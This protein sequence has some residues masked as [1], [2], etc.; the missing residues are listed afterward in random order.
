[1]PLCLRI[2]IGTTGTSSTL[3]YRCCARSAP[4]SAGKLVGLASWGEWSS[5]TRLE[6][7]PGDSALCGR[8]RPGAER[9]ASNWR[10]AFWSRGRNGLPEKNRSITNFR[11][12]EAVGYSDFEPRAGPPPSSRAG[13]R[14]APQPGGPFREAL[15][16]QGSASQ[17]LRWK[18][19]QKPNSRSS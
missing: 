10:R 8:A 18:Y 7:P 1:M 14:N 9:Q 6:S 16:G 11:S 15:A 12:L 3:R 19:L 13:T 17:E 4:R 5:Q 2:N